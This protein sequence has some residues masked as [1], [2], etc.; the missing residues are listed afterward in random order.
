MM[1]ELGTGIFAISVF[2][3]N[4]F[5]SGDIVIVSAHHGLFIVLV[6]QLHTIT[7]L[8]KCHTVVSVAL[9]ATYWSAQPAEANVLS[10][11]G[12]TSLSWN[13][14]GAGVTALLAVNAKSQTLAF[15]A[16]V[17]ALLAIAVIISIQNARLLE[18]LTTAPAAWL[19]AL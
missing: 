12:H 13:V 1:N 16:V 6:N 7:L 2:V 4:I 10:V 14:I 15:I 8:F 11:T 5:V 17:S 19:T 9:T 3:A 18:N